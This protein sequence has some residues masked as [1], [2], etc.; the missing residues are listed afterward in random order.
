MGNKSCFC[1]NHCQLLEVSS[2]TKGYYYLSSMKF[3]NKSSLMYE[4]FMRFDPSLMYLQG[5]YNSQHLGP[6]F[7]K[8]RLL[9]GPVSCPS[10]HLTSRF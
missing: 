10:L 6:V 2:C 9:T 3:W 1:E 8:S 5:N 4:K 7:R